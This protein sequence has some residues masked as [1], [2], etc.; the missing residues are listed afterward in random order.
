MLKI[1]SGCRD[2]NMTISSVNPEHMSKLEYKK[3]IINKMIDNIQDEE[4]I[5]FLINDMKYQLK[6]LYGEY[7]NCETCGDKTSY[8][9][10]EI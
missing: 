10:F 9:E 1:Y 2:D 5:N 8:E 6:L 7:D 3:L 4:F